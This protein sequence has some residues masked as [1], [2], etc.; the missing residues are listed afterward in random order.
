MTSR[1][2]TKGD[3]CDIYTAKE[4]TRGVAVKTSAHGRLKTLSDSTKD[5]YD[6]YI[7]CG[8]RVSSFFTVSRETGYSATMTLR[9]GDLTS[10]L[11]CGYS[12]AESLPSIT[13]EVK[14][15]PGEWHLWDGGVVDTLTLSA[16][17]IGSPIQLTAN[18]VARW[19]TSK[20]TG[21]AYSNPDGTAYSDPGTP[22]AGANTLPIRYTSL[23]T[24]DGATL[25]AKSW[26]LTL[27]NSVVSDPGEV[28]GMCL[29]AGSDAYP[30]D[31][32]ITLSMTIASATETSWDMKRQTG[33]TVT[34]VIVVDG[35]TLTV[36]GI[37]DAQGPDRQSESG[38]DETITLNHCSLKV[39]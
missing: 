4:T 8:S 5:T 21:Q 23:P 28:G 18:V 34:A 15:G 2:R 33:A 24:V 9:T 30:S 20:M 32:D 14:V 11:E 35:K 22:T 3:V 10:W 31:C 16:S 27:S 29:A 37:I 36:S 13:T 39:E 17:Q 26:T 38:Y 7:N 1:T 12:T 6:S 19:H 25:N